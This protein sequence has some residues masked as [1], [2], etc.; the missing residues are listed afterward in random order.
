ETQLLM[1]QVILH[2]C[3]DLWQEGFGGGFFWYSPCPCDANFSV[4]APSM[5]LG[6]MMRFLREQG[7]A[8]NSEE[9]ELIQS[10]CDNLAKAI[11]NTVNPPNGAPYWLYIPM[12][13]RYNR[14]SPNDLVHQVY[15]LWGIET[16]RDCGGRVKLPWTRAQAIE[17]VDRFVH[18]G[19]VF[20]LASD[21]TVH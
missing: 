3:R 13:N 11:V 2:W 10:R 18:D 9:R 4:N 17:S 14:K 8:L 6:A 15:T 7:S 19:R 21:E 1:K 5:F 20:S 12:P 16:Y